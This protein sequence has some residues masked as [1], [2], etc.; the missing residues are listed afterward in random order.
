MS[1]L[2]TETP[3][4][5]VAPIE[6][7]Q[8]SPKR[9]RE[10]AEIDDTEQIEELSP[11]KKRRM[12]QKEIETADLQELSKK[13]PQRVPPQQQYEPTSDTEE[14]DDFGEQTEEY[15]DMNDGDEID[16]ARAAALDLNLHSMD[17]AI[18]NVGSFD[19]LQSWIDSKI[20]DANTEEVKFYEETTAEMDAID[21]DISAGIKNIFGQIVGCEN[22][23]LASSGCVNFLKT[24]LNKFISLAILT[25]QIHTSLREENV[26]TVDDTIEAMKVLGRPVYLGDSFEDDLGEE[27]E[28]ENCTTMFDG[29]TFRGL[30][31]FACDPYYSLDEQVYF[32]IQKSAED[33]LGSLLQTALL[34]SES[35]RGTNALEVK[36][37]NAVLKLWVSHPGSQPLVQRLSTLAY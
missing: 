23:V 4:E 12:S 30:I 11:T 14:D 3:A 20:K 13:Y 33:I 36:D 18:M 2:I 31:D 29:N 27:D 34:L 22:S 25:A 7:T 32:V 17:E 15:S 6:S 21:L 9:T 19:Y 8:A 28:E 26:I 24:V 10:V 37:L 1:T 35:Y 16:D 5:T